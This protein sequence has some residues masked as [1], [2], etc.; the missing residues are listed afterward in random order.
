MS[1]LFIDQMSFSNNLIS[2]YPSS[3]FP[4]Y[5]MTSL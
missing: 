2:R 3:W 5:L 1:L 4:N